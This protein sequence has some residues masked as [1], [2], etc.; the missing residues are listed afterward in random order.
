[1]ILLDDTHSNSADP[2][3]RL[4]EEPCHHWLATHPNQIDQTLA[5]I[6]NALQSGIY[7]VTVFGYSLGEYLQGIPVRSDSIP[8]IEAF[9]FR[10]V[11]RL[12]RQEVSDLLAAHIQP[13][14]VLDVQASTDL[15]KF[16]Q[17]I[18]SI[19]RWI[20]SGDTYQVNHTFQ[21]SGA[22]YGPAAGLYR[23]LRER[24]PTSFGAFIEC[25]D[26]T[27]LSLSPELF[28][29][30]RG[31][32][33]KAKPMKGTLA[34]DRHQETDLS[35]DEKNRTENLM[36]VDLIRNDLGRISEIG[37]VHVPA[38]FEVEPFGSL[39]QMTSTVTGTLSTDIGLRELLVAT[40]PC[41]SVTG[42]PKK[43]TMEIIQTLEPH[44]RGVYCG[45]IGWFDPVTKA[46]GA[47]P[48]PKLGDFAMSVA[49]RTL[50]MD[51]HQRFRLGIGAG[52]TIDSEP[53]SEWNECLI[54]A[55][56]VTGLPTSIGLFETMRAENGAVPM[57]NAHMDRIEKSAAA[58]G[59]S[60]DRNTAHNVV[61]KAIADL[62]AKDAI[63]RVRLMLSPQGV[64]SAEVSPL[65]FF[66][67]LDSLSALVNR[68][69]IAGKPKVF[70]AS[71]LLPATLACVVSTNPLYRFKT[72]D[73]HAYDTAWQAAQAQGGFDALFVN[74]NGDVTEGGRSNLF[75]RRGQQ[76]LT[77]ALHCGVLP[78]LMRAKLLA[79]PTFNAQEAVISV[80]DVLT[81][82]DVLLVNALRGIIHV[83]AAPLHSTNP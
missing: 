23:Q 21:M 48:Q 83:D 33:L 22:M 47:T 81:A 43:R 77:P 78:G 31:R 62:S 41:G 32:Q 19:H 27:I 57:I 29:S 72:T 18:A 74:E 70:W 73:R 16:T 36:I 8:L 3:S 66:V 67:P 34:I 1:L 69:A 30:C 71:D 82:D 45:A 65:D 59:I 2:T 53:A 28:L 63:A 7:V 46:N 80:N 11:T 68:G 64:L 13:S 10:S 60:F 9:G 24:Q 55:G 75:I 54:K 61:A 49:I 39:F 40:F 50:E 6:Q 42:A 35:S 15:E 14:G 52:I 4:Y 76:W 44:S 58:L 37:S 17:D 38:M 20:E 56:F 79:D 26:R 12:S 25:Q 5:D 51:R